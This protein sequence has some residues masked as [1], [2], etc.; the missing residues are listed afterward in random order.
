MSGVFAAGNQAN[1]SS[2]AT[3]Y[4]TNDFDKYD[5]I[6]HGYVDANTDSFRPT[7]TL[8]ALANQQNIH[9]KLVAQRVRFELL[10]ASSSGLNGLFEFD[11]NQAV[12]SNDFSVSKINTAGTK[13]DP[14]ALVTSLAVISTTT[15][16]AGNFSTQDYKNIFAMR[17]GNASSLP[18]RGLNAA[19]LSTF[20]YGDILFVGGNFSDTVN[21]S[22]P[23]LSNVASFDTVKQV[24]HSLGNGVN[25]RVDSIVPLLLNITAGEPETCV[26]VNGA[27][28]QILASG[29]SKAFVA[30][31]GSAIW[32]P[33][34]ND[35]LQNLNS[36][37][38]AIRGQLSAATN[39]SGSS[40]LLAG[41]MSLAGNSVSDAVELSSSGYIS[42][43]PVGIHIT[44]QPVST[45][46][47]H[48]RAVT[49]QNVSG[50]VT[51]IFDTGSGRNNTIIAG[52]FTATAS[53]GSTINNLAIVTTLSSG[54]QNITGITNGLD[55]DSAFLA[56]AVQGD[57]LYAGGT[58]SGSANGAKVN[59]L[60]LW[61]LAQANYASAQP[62]PFAGSNVAVNTISSRP[63]SSEVYVGGSFDAVGSLSCPSLCVYQ[64]G[65]WSRPGT[66]LSGSIASLTWQGN[67]KLLVGGNLTIGGNATTL[68]FYDATKQLWTSVDGTTNIPGPVTALSAANNGAS[69]FWVAG[70]SLNGS[71]FLMKYDGSNSQSVGDTLGKQTTIRGLSVLAVSTCHD[72]TSL[73]DSCYVLL[74]TG[75]L[76]LPGFGNASAALFNGTTFSPFI[77]S[78]SGSGPG[79]LS[80]LFTEKQ[81]PF[82]ATG[83]ISTPSPQ[84]L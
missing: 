3:I 30:S 11:P 22:T 34:H 50:A 17:N 46:S 15:Y 24:W 2:Q 9:I 63:S 6:Y 55:T 28:D 21:P 72:D 44:P 77:L 23:G 7:I 4:Q 31:S 68:A 62:P 76:N 83:I 82:A 56:L 40:P 27:F 16:V 75:Q 66:G 5:Q 1:T 19:V 65:T 73:V 58:I 29:S 45:G 36:Q 74:I 14:G 67:D 12:V 20:V 25:G 41:T 43:N 42:L 13:L 60:V 35:W 32:V 53:N 33:S 38:M 80:Q 48:K 81:Q 47:K 71:A 39:I 49:G 70:K 57:T 26:T 52:H 64:G 51:G 59:G 54:D 79:S 37:S 84:I 18:N 78:N 61:N 69:Q 10:D 8:T